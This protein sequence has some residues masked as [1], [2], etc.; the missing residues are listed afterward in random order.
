[1]L[2]HSYFFDSVEFTDS[3]PEMHERGQLAFSAGA[4]LDLFASQS[5]TRLPDA[6]FSLWGS[7][8]LLTVIWVR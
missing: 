7:V 2:A 3:R 8:E 1:M 6:A 5:S 4:Y